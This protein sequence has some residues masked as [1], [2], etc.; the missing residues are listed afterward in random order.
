MI[1]CCCTIYTELKIK[2]H[3]FSLSANKS[4]WKKCEQHIAEEQENLYNQVSET[5][6]K[7]YE[8]KNAHG[9]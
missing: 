8:L 4:E 9:N 7:M 5:F 2:Q 1:F 6:W 3:K